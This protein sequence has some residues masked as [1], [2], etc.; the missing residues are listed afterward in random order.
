MSL[1]PPEFKVKVVLDILSGQK[2]VS[3]VCDE[4]KLASEQ[5]EGWINRF[6]DLAPAVFRQEV[7]QKEH[8]GERRLERVVAQLAVTNAELRAAIDN[9]KKYR[10]NDII[11][12]LSIKCVDLDEFLERLT[13]EAFPYL[14]SELNFG[15]VGLVEVEDGNAV[16]RF[17]YSGSDS[18]RDEES[19]P[20]ERSFAEKIVEEGRTNRAIR[21]GYQD[22][23]VTYFFALH[24][25]SVEEWYVFTFFCIESSYAD[26]SKLNIVYGFI[27]AFEQA[28]KAI[29]AREAID[30]LENQFRELEALVS[31]EVDIS[32][33]HATLFQSSV[34]SSDKVQIDIDNPHLYSQ[35]EQQ[36]IYRV[37]NENKAHIERVFDSDREPIAPVTV[38]NKDYSLYFAPIVMGGSVHRVVLLW[39]QARGFAL[40][41]KQEHAKDLLRL[42]TQLSKSNTRDSITGLANQWYFEQYL[43]C[44]VRNSRPGNNLGLF[45]VSI[46]GAYGRTLNSSNRRKMKVVADVVQDSVETYWPSI[47]YAWPPNIVARYERCVYLTVHRS[48]NADATKIEARKLKEFISERLQEKKGQLEKVST[49]PTGAHRLLDALLRRSN[50]N[51]YVGVLIFDSGA[52]ALKSSTYTSGLIERANEVLEFA[53]NDEDGVY[54]ARY[55]EV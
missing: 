7:K 29:C 21:K 30:S 4:Y 26:Q 31:S 17:G 6:E 1:H 42:V 14:V 25:K 55:D 50:I 27:N 20:F 16:Y 48:T 12:Q 22:E 19:L 13:E 46:R 2:S 33:L 11:H 47:S 37:L 5:V 38:R 15:K 54:V 40:A 41:Q 44:L 10:L 23:L 32:Y 39:I 8:W 49:D 36:R 53:E 43:E 18:I 3:R 52:S 45:V 34:L 28:V 51:V 35:K 24:G 9:V